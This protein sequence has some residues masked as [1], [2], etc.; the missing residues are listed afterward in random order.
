MVPVVLKWGTKKKMEARA[1]SFQVILHPEMILDDPLQW[2][3]L[4]SLIW[5]AVL[6]LSSPSI[7]SF[8]C[9]E[10]IVESAQ[11]IV[12]FFAERRAVDFLK[13]LQAN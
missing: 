13:D 12:C 2:L 11:L 1:D 8:P 6:F 3:Q 7:L 5:N 4:K 10:W 9:C